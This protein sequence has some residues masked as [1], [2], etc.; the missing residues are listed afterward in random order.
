MHA[1]AA[2]LS[3]GVAAVLA[4]LWLPLV[5]AVW[6]AEILRPAIRRLEGVLGGRRRAAAAVVVLLV[7]GALVPITG[8]VVVLVSGAGDLLDQVRS[9]AE[10]HGSLAGVLLGRDGAGTSPGVQG[11]ADLA[12]RY[13]ASAWRALSTVARIS[14][15]AAIAFIVFTATL[16]TVAVDGVRAYA[17]VE[18]H[19]PIPREAFARLARAFRETGRGLLIAGGGTALVQGGIATLAYVAIGIPRALLFG[20]LTAACAIVPFVGTALVWAPLAIELAA[21]GEYWRAG[22]L[23]AAGA[24][25][26]IVDNFVRPALARYGRLALPT[27]VVFVSMVGGVAVFGA[28]GALLGPLLVRLC[29]EALAI[30]ADRPGATPSAG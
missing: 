27:C 4:P 16:Y 2:A 18:S 29:V 9:A 25:V 11:W 14:A 26:G 7:V 28:A 3:V 24:G 8:S 15:N 30:V 21:A 22:A 23:A 13:G 20:L 19:A 5:L 10:G 1:L 6:F 12:T 17:W